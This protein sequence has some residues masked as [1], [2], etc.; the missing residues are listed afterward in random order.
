M[1][2]KKL[3][4]KNTCREINTIWGLLEEHHK[5]CSTILKVLKFLDSCP[6]QISTPCPA[7][8]ERTS[9]AFWPWN[10]TQYSP[11]RTC[12]EVSSAILATNST[13]LPNLSYS[14]SQS[15]LAKLSVKTTHLK[16][17]PWKSQYWLFKG[18]DTSIHR[19]PFQTYMQGLGG[20]TLTS[21]LAFFPVPSP[22]KLALI[23]TE[24]NTGGNYA[25]RSLPLSQILS[26]FPQRRN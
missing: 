6:P 4:S 12:T 8:P 9:R 16:T 22:T 2:T 11:W 21:R 15:R 19:N 7:T 23:A 20:N 24:P 3:W 26:V 5:W 14:L 1:E 13:Q 17:L 18:H 25:N 10:I